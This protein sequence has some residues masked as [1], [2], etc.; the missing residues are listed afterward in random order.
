M[1]LAGRN[2]HTWTGFGG[3]DPEGF[4]Y[5]DSGPGF[6]SQNNIPQLAQFVWT[7]S[8]AF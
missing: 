1:T 2:L 3:L 4:F 7:V 6:H 8:V 5:D